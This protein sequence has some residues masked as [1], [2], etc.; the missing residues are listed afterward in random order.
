MKHRLATLPLVLLLALSGYAGQE[1]GQTC[2]QGRRPTDIEALL[3]KISASLHLPQSS[4][5]ERIAS[6]S[7]EKVEPIDLRDVT[8]FLSKDKL[9]MPL[10][11]TATTS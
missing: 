2:A 6:R 1:N 7:G 11:W 8:H 10:R 5:L 9:T 3:A 4:W